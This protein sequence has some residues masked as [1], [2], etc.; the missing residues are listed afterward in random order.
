M[1]T[2]WLTHTVNTYWVHLKLLTQDRMSNANTILSC[3]KIVIRN[4]V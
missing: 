4:I 2:E 3:Q 1:L